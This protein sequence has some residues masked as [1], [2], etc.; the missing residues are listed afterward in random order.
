M[1]GIR[2]RATVD[3]CP[4]T[5][6]NYRKHECEHMKRLRTGINLVESQVR[7]NRHQGMIEEKER[8]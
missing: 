3:S 8:R 1:G 2:Y 7:L 6:H 4:C 5:D